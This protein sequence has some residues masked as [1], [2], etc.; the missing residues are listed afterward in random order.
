MSIVSEDD[1]EDEN[2]ILI[3]SEPEGRLETVLRVGTALPDLL[4]L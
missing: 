3:R 4:L 2:V 1:N